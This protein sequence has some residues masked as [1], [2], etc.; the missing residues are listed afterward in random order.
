MF[1]IAFGTMSIRSPANVK[2]PTNKNIRIIIGKNIGLFKFIKLFLKLSYFDD[3]LN[4]LAI[5][6]MADFLYIAALRGI[7]AVL[8][9][10]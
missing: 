4:L 10:K 8:L 6:A 5:G 2:R 3:T 1:S 9:K 7:I